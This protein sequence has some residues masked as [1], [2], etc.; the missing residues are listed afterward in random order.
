MAAGRQ[1]ISRDSERLDDT[2]AIPSTGGTGKCVSTHARLVSKSVGCKDVGVVRRKEVE[3]G[4]GEGEKNVR[5]REG[6]ATV[7]TRL[8][9]EGAGGMA[10][11]KNKEVVVLTI[12]DDGKVIKSV[13]LDEDLEQPENFVLTGSE[14]NLINK[15]VIEYQFA[16]EDRDWA[17]S[18]FNDAADF[19]GLFLTDVHKWT[20]KEVWYERGAWVRIYGTPVHAWNINFFKLCVSKCGRF[21]REDECTLERG[22]IDFA[23]ILI[24]TYSLEVLNKMMVLMVDG[25]NYNIKLVEECGC[26]LGEYTFLIEEVVEH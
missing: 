9:K 4:T 14:G 7:Q 22:R 23:R 1:D 26:N 25:C 20:S 24:S 2:D 3:S 12:A 6:A 10:V 19:F 21:V 17:G 13:D 5:K 18:V 8:L 16:E 11:P 15:G